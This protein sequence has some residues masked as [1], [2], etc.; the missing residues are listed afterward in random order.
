MKNFY[1]VYLLKMP[2]S[3]HRSCINIL[4]LVAWPNVC[5][6]RKHEIAVLNPAQ[7]YFFGTSLGQGVFWHFS[8]FSNFLHST[9]GSHFGVFDVFSLKIVFEPEGSPF[10]I[11]TLQDVTFSIFFSKL[12]I[13]P[14][15]IFESN[16]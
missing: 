5:V 3:S 4:H 11:F 12:F 9:E 7:D 16:E 10:W 6:I 13:I 14:L 1:Y 15:K 2:H 8:V